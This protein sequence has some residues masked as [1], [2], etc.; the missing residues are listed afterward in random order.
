MALPLSENNQY[1][2]TERDRRKMGNQ[3]CKS[4][5]YG[6]KRHANYKHIGGREMETGKSKKTG[7]GKGDLITIDKLIRDISNL[8]CRITKIGDSAW[9]IDSWEEG[10]ASCILISS[11]VSKGKKPSRH[12]GSGAR[13]G[14]GKKA[15]RRSRDGTRS[16]G[17]SEP[18]HS[19][20]G[21]SARMD[22]EVARSNQIAS[23][24]PSFEPS[25]QSKPIRPRMCKASHPRRN[26]S[27]LRY[28]PESRGGV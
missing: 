13:M 10:R 11:A 9:Q 12:E 18:S 26:Q 22:N 19:S 21:G 4:M 2:H 5:Y 28:H 1:A 15:S 16:M 7:E 6:Q 20:D 25:G 8:G 27:N 14:R 17:R 3:S 23:G 24:C